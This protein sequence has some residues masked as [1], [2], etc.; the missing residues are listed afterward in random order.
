[1][2]EFFAKAGPRQSSVPEDKREALLTEL[3]ELVAEFNAADD[4][5]VE[6]DS[7]YA[8]VVARKKS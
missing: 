4:G 3:L 5:S 7:A 6:I 8:I 2:G 1:M